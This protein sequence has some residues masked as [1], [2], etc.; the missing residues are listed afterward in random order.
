MIAISVFEFYS[1]YGANPYVY[2]GAFTA[3]TVVTCLFLGVILVMISRS[4]ISKMDS[5]NSETI[6]LSASV[7]SVDIE[8]RG[9]SRAIFTG[10]D[11]EEYTF[12]ISKWKAAFLS[13][14][15]HGELRFKGDKFI[16][17][18]TADEVMEGN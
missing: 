8:K 5:F 10:D 6:T 11:G 2:M 3:I 13:I 15:E 12:N 1:H 17:F 16:R 7:T 14:G 4:M 9:Q 18:K